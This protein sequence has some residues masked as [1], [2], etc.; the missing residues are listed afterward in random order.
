M[1]ELER[2]VVERRRADP[3]AIASRIRTMRERFRDAEV[4]GNEDSIDQMTCDTGDRHVVA[5]AVRANAEVIAAAYESPPMT[6]EK[7]LGLIGK[8]GAPKFAARF[9]DEL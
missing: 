7:F 5:A 3:A 1:G 8:S 9:L 4:K 2:V 6:T